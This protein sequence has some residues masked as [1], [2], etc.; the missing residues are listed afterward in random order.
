[1]AQLS[2][3]VDKYPSIWQFK[4]FMQILPTCWMKV[5]FKLGWKTKVSAIKPKI[6]LLGNKSRQLINKTFDKMH[7]LGYIKFI[8]KHIPFSFSMFI[9]WKIDTKDKK[10][11][12]VI[13]DIWKLNEM[14]LPNSYFLPLQSKIIANIQ[15]C[16]NFA[17]L[18]TT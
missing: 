11:G 12:K 5:S 10:K 9:V 8:S 13:V 1:M 7:R 16:T 15:G 18:D 2:Q 4:G 6:Y 17:I 3:L 14:I